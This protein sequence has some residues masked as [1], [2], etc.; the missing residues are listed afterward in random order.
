MI[1][2]IALQR[3]K[4]RKKVCTANIPHAVCLLDH[5][6]GALRLEVPNALKHRLG[7]GLNQKL[8]FEPVCLVLL[9]KQ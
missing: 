4:I 5:D 7:A 9:L 6:S 1:A 3:V 8:A 2:A